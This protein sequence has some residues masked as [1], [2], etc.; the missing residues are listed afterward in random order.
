MYV[1]YIYINNAYIQYD[2]VCRNTNKTLGPASVDETW[3]P[4]R[5][6][7]LRRIKKMRCLKPWVPH[8][9]IHIYIY[10]YVYI[11]ICMYVYIY[12]PSQNLLEYVR[13]C[14]NLLESVRICQNMLEYVRTCQNAS[15]CG[16]THH[17][18][19]VGDGLLIGVAASIHTLG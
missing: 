19:P 11:Y 1:T 18:L 4:P 5:Q 7:R 9:S 15:S 2:M 10:V 17:D 14:L 3:D 8:R 16:K 13:I 6:C 12:I